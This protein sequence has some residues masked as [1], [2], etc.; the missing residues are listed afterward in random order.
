MITLRAVITLPCHLIWHYIINRRNSALVQVIGRPWWGDIMIQLGRYI[1]TRSSVAQS[2]II[3]DR[4]KSY[5]IALHKS[6]KDFKGRK[7][8]LS[9]VSVNGTAGRWTAP[10]GTRRSEDEVVMFYCHGGGFV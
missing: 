7:D 10:P 9:Y 6:Q 5:K 1:L 8:W 3:F 4:V 2:R